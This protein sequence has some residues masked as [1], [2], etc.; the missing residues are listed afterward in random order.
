M[1][2]LVSYIEMTHIK[3]KLED[4][5]IIIS[6]NDGTNGQ[7]WN[8]YI[9][10]AFVSIFLHCVALYTGVCL[11]WLVWSLDLIGLYFHNT[12]GVVSIT[13]FASHLKLKFTKFWNVKQLLLFI[14]NYQ[15]PSSCHPSQ[16][17]D[18]LKLLLI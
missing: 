1:R 10:W 16:H 8:P 14:W 3:N 4:Y 11:N 13:L 5:C 17:N 18:L 15:K 7:C 9:F 12:K 2:M 6:S